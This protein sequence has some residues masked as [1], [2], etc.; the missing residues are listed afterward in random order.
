MK[1][2]KQYFKWNA[3][4]CQW[5]ATK[6]NLKPFH[7]FLTWDPSINTAATYYLTPQQWRRKLL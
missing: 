4:S 1:G 6:E 2:I 3:D 5:F 7:Y